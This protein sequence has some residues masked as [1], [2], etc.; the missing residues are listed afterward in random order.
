VSPPAS[1]GGMYWRP[2]R[3]HPPP[4]GRAPAR[5]W[6]SPRPQA[7]TPPVDGRPGAGMDL[8][9]GSPACKALHAK[10]PGLSA[11]GRDKSPSTGSSAACG[12]PAERVRTCPSLELPCSLAS[13]SRGA[14]PAG[15]ASPGGASRGGAP[16]G[17]P[18][19]GG[20]MPPRRG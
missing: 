3:G 5:G 18:T 11:V 2:L 14:A 10:Q 13:P 16:R 4:G 12:R 15:A 9:T 20:S 8:P 17:A 7:A 6:T 1:P 19:R